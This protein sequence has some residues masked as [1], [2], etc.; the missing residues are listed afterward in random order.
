MPQNDHYRVYTNANQGA[1][2]YY[3]Q[4]K[5]ALPSSIDS[6]KPHILSQRDFGANKSLNTIVTGYHM[7]PT[8]QHY[9]NPYAGPSNNNVI[10]MAGQGGHALY[11]MTQPLPP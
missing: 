7:P 1:L 4:T 9:P 11:P 8:M 3:S 2:D 5:P 10:Y 6:G